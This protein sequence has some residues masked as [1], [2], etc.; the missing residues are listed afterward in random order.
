[1]KK[2]SAKKSEVL[3]NETDIVELDTP[4]ETLQ[5]FGK[6]DVPEFIKD[7]S[8]PFEAIEIDM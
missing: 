5:V 4:N 3:V 7:Y 2:E 8:I 6:I 1:M